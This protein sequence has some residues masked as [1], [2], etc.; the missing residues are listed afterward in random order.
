MVQFVRFVEKSL[1]QLNTKYVHRIR[2][3][4][5]TTTT[6]ISQVPFKNIAFS[7][8]SWQTFLG[9]RASI[10]HGIVLSLIEII[11]LCH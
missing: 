10:P 1:G 6:I 7:T 11:K 3:E 2:N 9:L 5:R 4:N 8:I